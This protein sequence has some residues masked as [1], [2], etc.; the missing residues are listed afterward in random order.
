M[1]S[2]NNYLSK[3][4]IILVCIKIYNLSDFLNFVLVKIIFIMNH[5]LDIVILVLYHHTFYF[6]VLLFVKYFTFYFF[7]KQLFK[8]FCLIN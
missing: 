7:N 1:L 6:V 2:Q 5:F 8:I 3:L 4:Y